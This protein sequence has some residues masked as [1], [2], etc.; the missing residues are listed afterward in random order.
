MVELALEAEALDVELALLAESAASSAVNRFTRS[1]LSFD[2]GP[3]GRG[4]AGGGADVLLAE[5]TD[6]A[7]VVLE[8]DVDAAA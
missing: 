2:T 8:L 6:E 3:G 7:D 1:P 4:G 5:L